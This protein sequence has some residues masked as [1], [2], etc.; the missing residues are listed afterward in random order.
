MPEYLCRFYVAPGVSTSVPMHLDTKNY[1]EEH[2]E[3]VCEEY[4]KRNGLV[5][6]YFEE[7][8]HG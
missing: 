3:T 8:N 5:F 4:A 1:S 6:S 2:L 7:T